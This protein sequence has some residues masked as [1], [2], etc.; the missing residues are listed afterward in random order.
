M[1]DKPL[2]QILLWAQM[3]LTPPPLRLNLFKTISIFAPTHKFESI[4]I[5]AGV[6]D[7][8]IWNQI[9]GPEGQSFDSKFTVPHI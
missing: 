9:S 1:F 8:E 3:C 2:P 7:E 4:S 6:S 5:F